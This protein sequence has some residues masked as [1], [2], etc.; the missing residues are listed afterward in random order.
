MIKNEL[1]LLLDEIGLSLTD[2]QLEDFDRYAHML[3]SYNQNV[4]LT[5]LT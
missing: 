5:A 1:S 3:V 4:N 2:K